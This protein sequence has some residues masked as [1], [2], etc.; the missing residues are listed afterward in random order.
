MKRRVEVAKGLLHNPKV[1]L[2]DEPTTGLDPAA[3]RDLWQYL[4]DLKANTGITIVFTTHLMEEAARADQLLILDR[5]RKVA[6][7]SPDA[8]REEIGGDVVTIETLDPAG[9]QEKITQGFGMT[10][11]VMNGGLRLEHSSGVTFVPQLMDRFGDDVQAVTVGKPT[12]EDV[13]IH[14]TGHK[15]FEEGDDV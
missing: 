15:F 2:L 4:L 9:L 3:R 5:G 12:L 7:G 1:L 8:L 6:E 11:S 13:F 14:K 10:P